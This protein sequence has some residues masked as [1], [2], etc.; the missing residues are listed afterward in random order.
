[1]AEDYYKILGLEKTATEADI[2]RA[3]RKLAHQYHPDKGNG[4]EKKFKE[5]SEAYQILSD[6]EKRKQYDQF[7]KTSDDQD[8]QEQG[9][10]GFDWS[11]F[12]AQGGPASGWDFS[13][14]GDIFDT[15]FGGERRNRESRGADLERNIEI[16]FEEAAKGVNLP[17]ELEKNIYCDC[18]KITCPE[19]Q[20]V[21]K[22]ETLRTTILGQF[23][24]I[25]TCAK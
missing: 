8:G 5:V 4:D 2:K 3:Y 9:F 1:M 6:P 20:G 13:N 10:G 17:I 15:F 25:Q 7:G 18:P 21:G 23:K 16:T 12:S 22:K 19:C 11:E 24:S 14:L